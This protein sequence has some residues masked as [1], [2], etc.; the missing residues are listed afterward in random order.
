MTQY[1]RAENRSVYLNTPY[2]RSFVQRFLGLDNDI[3]EAI[4]GRY[5]RGKRKGQLRGVVTFVRVTEGG[6]SRGQNGVRYPGVDE[7]SVALW[8]N[9]HTPSAKRVL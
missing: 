7:N 6:W 4:V 5:S 9:Y 2:G 3:I 1:A 8:I